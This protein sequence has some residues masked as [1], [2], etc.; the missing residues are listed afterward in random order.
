[1]G[2]GGGDGARER[3][4]DGGC[5][6]YSS[7]GL[8]QA[9][10]RTRTPSSACSGVEWGRTDGRMGWWTDGQVSGRTGGWVDGRV[11]G[12]LVFVC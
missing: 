9:V 3:G 10:Q 12:C 11:G 6:S 7:S 8:A 4:R 1:M 2:E 5:G